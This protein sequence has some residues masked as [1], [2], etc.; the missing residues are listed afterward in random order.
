MKTIDTFLFIENVELYRLMYK[1]IY[2]YILK[3]GGDLDISETPPPNTT[4][5]MVIV[6][7]MFL[8]K[9]YGS[10]EQSSDYLQKRCM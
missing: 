8:L 4:N 10:M 7:K 5:L 2:N 6:E 3:S 9:Q 1:K